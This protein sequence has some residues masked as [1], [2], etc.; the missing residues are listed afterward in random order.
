[1][2]GSTAKLRRSDWCTVQPGSSMTSY[3]LAGVNK[4]HFMLV[5]TV[6]PGLSDT[7]RAQPQQQH[8]LLEQT[9]AEE[10][11]KA[12]RRSGTASTLHPGV[13]YKQ[14]NTHTP[15]TEPNTKQVTAY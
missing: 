14:V 7:C 5:S 2:H 13:Q 1:M 4:P 3:S 10:M 15:P 12:Q 6:K 11:S 9:L 8:E